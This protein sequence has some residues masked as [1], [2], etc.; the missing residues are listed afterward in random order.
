MQQQ[1]R[2]R[3]GATPYIISALTVAVQPGSGAKKTNIHRPEILDIDMLCSLVGL[4][5]TLMER[6]RG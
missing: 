6:T 2:H 1:Q 4:R 3:E 5:T